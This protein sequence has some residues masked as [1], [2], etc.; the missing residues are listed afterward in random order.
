L[1][2]QWTEMAA[3][4]VTVERDGQSVALDALPPSAADAVL[5]RYLERAASFGLLIR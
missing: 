4:E 5:E 3:G 1:I 2:R